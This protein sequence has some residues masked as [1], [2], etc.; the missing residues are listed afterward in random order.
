MKFILLYLRQ[1]RRSILFYIGVCLIFALTFR[2][3]HLP[4]RAVIYP[5]L[6]CGLFAIVWIITDMRRTLQRHRQLMQIQNRS[7]A[8]IKNLPSPNTIFDADYQQIIHG[9]L[10]E[11]RRHETMM[12][13]RMNDIIDYYTL[14][15]HQIKTPIAAMRLHLQNEDT[16]FSRRMSSELMRIEQYVE[17]VLAY[18]RLDASSTDYVIR[19]FDLDSVI[20]Q[21]LRR[22]SGEF[23][24]RRLKLNYTPVQCTVISDEKWLAFIIEQI[25]SNAL[26]Y[27]PEGSISICMEKHCVLSIRDTGIGIAPED[28][29]RI[30]ENGFT[31]LNG[32]SDKKASGLGL[33]L[34]RRIC[35]K[36][37]HEIWIE[38]A[39]DQ[40]TTVFIDLSRYPFHAE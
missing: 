24:L 36:L 20:R 37:N 3:Y 13:T 31:G 30:F 8:L 7:A 17:M 38:S 27:T 33:H 9:L 14:W 34:C 4:V 40:G 22:F 32:R 26:K 28:M 29:P 18:L 25:L 5:S 15:A 12:S 16:A 23:I 11:Q 6:L 35:R 10:D 19:E 21:C 1:R 39:I 2:L